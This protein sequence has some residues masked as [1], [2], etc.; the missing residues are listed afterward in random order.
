MKRLRVSALGRDSSTPVVAVLAVILAACSGGPS[1]SPATADPSSYVVAPTADPGSSVVVPAAT[2]MPDETGPSE[3]PSPRASPSAFPSG[4]EVGDP[5]GPPEVAVGDWIASTVE[6]LRLREEPGINGPSVGLL[7]IGYEGTVIDGPV[8]LDGYEWIHIAWPGLPAGS[9]CATGPDADG[10]LSFCGASGWVA[11]ADPNGNAWVVVGSPDCPE[12]PTTVEQASLIRPGVRLTCFGG[13][14]LTLTGFLAPE[15]QGR[16]CYPGYDHNPEW[17]GPCAVAFLQGEESQY[18]G[19]TFELVVHV[20]SELGSCHFGGTSPETCPFL[21]HV[22]TW[23]RISGVVDHPSAES[24]VIDPWEGN[25][26]AFDAASA[27]YA[28]RERFVVTSIQAGSA[29]P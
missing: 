25:Q 29:P 26:H 20:H 10:Y 1:G 16:G 3:M 9:G 14:E 15:A 5:V 22:G 4:E 11:T 19:T 27:V 21:P 18:D 23:V 6:G 13:D 2:P 8:E 17:L 28:C 7:R 12:P 24:C